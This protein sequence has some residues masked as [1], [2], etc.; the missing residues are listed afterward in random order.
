MDDFD[1]YDEFGN[2]IGAGGANGEGG[3]NNVLSE[4]DEYE[5]DLQGEEMAYEEGEGNFEGQQPQQHLVQ[6]HQVVLHEDK[7]YYPSALEVYGPGI[8]IS[9]QDEDTQMLSEPIIAPVQEVRIVHEE[10]GA[11][12]Q[13]ALRYAPTADYFHHLADIKS[14]CRAVAFVGHIHHGKTALLDC[15]IAAAHVQAP[16]RPRLHLKN[17]RSRSRAARY[18]DCLEQERERGISLRMKS[19]SLPLQSASNMTT[20]MFDCIDAPGHPDFRSEMAMALGAATDAAVLVVDAVEGVLSGTEACLRAILLTGRPCILVLNKVERLWLE[21]KLAPLDAY[22]KLKHTIDSLNTIAGRCLFAPETGNVVFASAQDGWAFSLPSWSRQFYPQAPASLFK[23]LWGDIFYD[24]NGK[25]FHRTATESN[26]KRSFVALV[27][28]PLYK[29]YTSV[30]S[31][32]D[33]ESLQARLAESLGISMKLSL[34]KRYSTPSS[35]LSAILSR[36]FQGR[37]VDGFIDAIIEHCPAPETFSDSNSNDDDD[38]LEMIVCKVFPPAT[39]KF[40]NAA[41]TQAA[42]ESSPRLLCR[43]L[44]GSLRVGQSLQLMDTEGET[45]FA[46]EPSAIAVPCTRYEWPVTGSTSASFVLLSGV[47]LD[48]VLKS[49][50]ITAAA[51]VGG[52]S[53]YN[54]IAA[55]RALATVEAI[56]RAWKL[57]SLLRVSCEP[58]TPSELPRMLSGLRLLSCLYPS[59][60][61]HVEEN[62]EHVLFVPGELYGDCILHDLRHFTGGIGNAAT[63]PTSLQ[64][65]ISDPSVGFAEGVQELSTVKCFADTMNGRL[66]ISMIA[67]PLESGLPEFLVGNDLMSMPAAER[68]SLLTTRF[69][70]DKVSVRGLLAVSGSC[71]LVDDTFGER[72]GLLAAI[73]PSLIQGFQWACREGPLCEAPM[74][75]VRF[76]LCGLELLTDAEESSL[77]SS[78]LNSLTPAQIVP[79]ARRACYSAFLTASPRLLEPVL[80]VQITAPG[81]CIEAIYTTLSRRRGHVLSDLPLPSTP[82]YC[83][84]ALLPLLDSAGFEVDLRVGTSGAAFATASFD[85]WQLIPGD[86][87]DTK[88]GPSLLEPATAP[89]LARDCLLKTRKRRGLSDDVR[90]DKFFDEEMREVLAAAKIF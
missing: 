57:N 72:A 62:G 3:N 8:E 16:T 36:F 78:S 2:Y 86:P 6:N 82:L 48:R 69:N 43:L 49:G 81:E 41:D 58:I 65:R 61:T 55:R 75:G 13:P 84:N 30:L 44:K 10:G 38:G 14:R 85:H 53:N 46:I 20:Y 5:E 1:L 12:G 83:I 18:L 70:W 35:M 9:V 39:I 76:R 47:P 26:F 11:S 59:L 17:S 79:A 88:I 42:M 45:C 28:E 7:K 52:A 87:L 74:R 25:R 34:L 73:R 24:G 54:P 67:E 27:L 32:P 21:L 77:S 37:P 64:V 90:I 63:A 31:A 71:V 33:H 40:K 4:I 19:I 80:A 51:A 23:R 29:L 50:I 68:S 56:E 15:L 60:K 89:A 22:F 66:R